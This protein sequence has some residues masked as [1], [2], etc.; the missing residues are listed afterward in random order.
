MESKPD[1]GVR[2]EHVTGYENKYLV[3]ENGEIWSVVSGQFLSPY[4]SDPKCPYLRVCLYKDGE[5]RQPYVHTV[6]AYAFLGDPPGDEF[7][8][9]H[10][11]HDPANNEA[12]NLEWM[13]NEDHNE[14]HNGRPKEDDELYAEEAPF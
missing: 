5:K 11:D 14:Y 6:V 12:S 2:W 10:K 7:Q 13:K 9:H 8:V 3:S 1:R 4:R